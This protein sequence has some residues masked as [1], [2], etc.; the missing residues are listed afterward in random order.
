MVPLLVFLCVSTVAAYTRLNY[1]EIEAKV[2]R[3]RTSCSS[4]LNVTTAQEAYHVP[5]PSDCGQCKHWVIEFTRAPAGSPHVFF[6][7]AL[8]GD[9]RLGPVTTI[10]L[11][12]FLCENF[13]TN[14]W[15]RHLVSSTRLI[16][17][18]MPNP[19]GYYL[20][21]R[22]EKVHG[23]EQDPNRD[24]GYFVQPNQCMQTT[25][26]QAIYEILSHRIVVLS[27][28]FHGGTRAVGY[29]W[30]APN[31]MEGGLSSEA[32][33]KIAA[34]SIGNAA[35]NYSNL[36]TRLGPMTDTVYEVAGGM[37]DWA[38]AASWESGNAVTKCSNSD[39]TIHEYNSY[40]FRQLMYLVEMDNN[41]NPE[42][43]RLGSEDHVFT[44]DALVPTY[45]RFSLAA[46]TMAKPYVESYYVP[47]TDSV[48]VFWRV[49]GCEEVDETFLLVSPYSA[50]LWTRLSHRDYLRH[51]DLATFERIGHSQR[52]KCGLDQPT[53]FRTHLSLSAP[54]L[55]LVAAKVD[56]KWAQQS[57]PDPDVTPQSHVVKMRTEEYFI[58]GGD[59]F[60]VSN[61][62]LYS[63]ALLF[64]GTTSTTR[65]FATLVDANFEVQGELHLEGHG[66]QVYL[67]LTLK[68]RV[69]ANLELSEFGD[70]RDPELRTWGP[71]MPLERLACQGVP[72]LGYFAA[73]YEVTFLACGANPVPHF[74]GRTAIITTDKGLFFGVLETHDPSY[75]VNGEEGVCVIAS[76][77]GVTAT[78]ML[79]ADIEATKLFGYLPQK[80][81]YTA[82]LEGQEALIVI[83]SEA[84]AQQTQPVKLE[85]SL[86]SIL[87]RKLS[88]SL[89][90]QEIGSCVV[91]LLN[92][93]HSDPLFAH[94]HNGHR[95]LQSALIIGGSSGLSLVAVFLVCYCSRK[96]A[97]HRLPDTSAGVS[98]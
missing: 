41:K 26:A 61:A 66:T 33:D 7:G 37:E 21:N 90:S 10:A 78:F 55:L 85:R 75:A 98:P 84:I 93:R 22:G 79:D 1:S 50:E 8:H 73:P 96:R 27:I 14:P 77:G 70:L 58:Q 3:L 74:V 59:Y 13:P 53:T 44:S 6:S 68:P 89:G 62:T 46:I 32:P 9:E 56:S 19:Q 45:L 15:V 91:G 52:G 97:Y 48:E 65:L 2:E 11:A 86:K 40:S 43:M 12:E 17:M 81:N 30:G 51:E 29:P 4:L 83:S 57:H 69:R 87:G 88:L 49:R 94:S 76:P 36:T 28:T 64:N 20:F 95:Q 72:D 54:S 38:Y 92:P 18:P 25:T 71:S 39:Y 67:Q 31:H 42:D 5:M 35:I 60:L 82:K 23:E 34:H 47:R 63:S 16:L 80:G 24:F